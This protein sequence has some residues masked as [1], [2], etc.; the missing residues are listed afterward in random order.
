MSESTSTVSMASTAPKKG[1]GRRKLSLPVILLIVAGG[2]ALFSLVR[3]ISGADDLTSVGQVSGALQ[4]AVPIGLAGLG[5]LWAERAGVINIGLEGM[6]ILGTWFGA[7]AGYQWGPWTGVLLGIAGGALGGLLHAVMTVTF[8]VNHIVSGVAITILATG[9]TRYMSNFTFAETEGGSSKQSPRIDAIERITIPGLSDWL[10]DLQAKHWF[11]VSDLAGVLGGLVTNLSLL[12]VVALLLV[13]GT[14]W[15]LWRTS[16]GLRLRSCG[17]NPIAAESLGVNVYKY[18]YIAVIVSGGLAGLG[19]AFLAII[20]GIYQEG[21]TG[22]R[23]Y[24][25]LAAM[26]FGN[27]MPGG[28]AL[29]AGLFGFTDSLKLRGGAVNVHAMLLL[30][31]ILLL[32]AVV[33]QLYRKKYVG[34]VISAAFSAL[35]FTWYALTDEL[36]SQFVDA[37]P[38]VA[39]LLV[40]AVSAQRLRMPK[41]NGQPYFRGQGK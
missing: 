33:W 30:L 5:G 39:T 19:G 28:M 32:I 36:P 6:M 31:A 16:F 21:Q 25:G 1:G 14:W 20:T 12:T 35:L 3:V 7:W 2:L 41:A 24:I 38:Y 22:G 18:K 17:E 23:G 34:A 4:L 9:L 10:G 11:F 27:W 29:G 26:I 8:K 15:L 13:P 40:L 37:A